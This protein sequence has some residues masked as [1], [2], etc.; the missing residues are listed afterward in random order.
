METV[1]KITLPLSVFISYAPVPKDE[2]LRQELEAHL[3]LLKKLGLITTW[4]HRK[5]LAG[6]N[7]QQDLAEHLETATLILLL[8]SAD[9]LNNE[10][11]YQEMETA[12]ERSKAGNALVIPIILRKVHL[13]STA[14]KH[15]LCLP[16]DGR[17]VRSWED[18]D[19]AFTIIIAEIRETI[20]KY[21]T[22]QNRRISN[23]EK[24]LR[25]LISDHN[26]FLKDRLESFVGRQHELA[27]IQDHINQWLPT[28][29]YITITGQ[30]GQGKSSIIAK[31]IETCGIEQVA[32]HFISINPGPDHQ[33][34][35]LRNLMARLLLKYDLSDLYVASD[36]R[37]ALRDYFPKVLSDIANQRRQ[38]IIFID[39]LDQLEEDFNGVRD[40]SF[41]PTNPPPGIVFVLGTRPND[42]M[43]PLELLK[44]HHE[45][46]LPNLSRQDFDRILQHRDVSLKETIA[47]QFYKIMGENAL[48][49][50]LVAKELMASDAID[51][52]DIITRITAN[53]TNVFTLSLERL[54]RQWQLWEHVIYPVL[55]VLLTTQE[56]LHLRSMVDILQVED[57]KMRD[58]I[59]KLGGLLTEDTQ[60]R[61]S[62]FHLKLQDYLR[63]DIKHP[64]KEY[65]F[66][67]EEEEGWHARFAL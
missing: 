44:P 51:P 43:K 13:E 59:A 52:L 50:D 14:F 18:L 16:R 62:L 56:P 19:E 45:Y 28:G 63:Q 48:Y 5:A 30:A 38:E 32:Y 54:K 21:P 35:L 55:G 1:P 22:Q 67:K 4:H 58:G 9:F 10:E 34:G 6:S 64:Q 39:G 12:L 41:L 17:P 33:V 25:A 7:V 8:I 49:L 66:S 47:D 2:A 61:Y 11:C 27:E 36:N 24:R 26:G 31:L 37:A 46:R 65:L 15:L 29:G 42:T 40:L 23:K 20:E 53:P 60:R 57:Y 3:S